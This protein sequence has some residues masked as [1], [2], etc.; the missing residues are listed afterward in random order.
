MCDLGWKKY[1]LHEF[2]V[3]GFIAIRAIERLLQECKQHGHDDGGLQRLSEDDE[4]DR[5]GEDVDGHLDSRSH[6]TQVWGIVR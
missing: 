3:Y 4:E 6:S 1:L 5:D 2:L